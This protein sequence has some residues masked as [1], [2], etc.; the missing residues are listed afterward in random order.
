MF[1]VLNPS[2][3]KLIIRTVF[4]I[5]LLL[6]GIIS[7]RLNIDHRAEQGIYEA[8]HKVLGINVF[9]GLGYR[10]DPVNHWAQTGYTEIK[11][12]FPLWG[13]PIIVG[14]IQN[15]LVIMVIQVTAI[16]SLLF[17]IC[18][19]YIDN[20]YFLLF[21]P[22]FL[23][24]ALHATVRWADTWYVLSLLILLFSLIRY[25]EN[26][27]RI[28][29]VITFLISLVGVNIRPDFLYFLIFLFVTFFCILKISNSSLNSS[30]RCD[31]WIDS[32]ADLY[33]ECNRETFDRKHKWWLSCLHKSWTAS[34]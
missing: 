15:D 22:L 8:Y 1:N 30:C 12:T 33:M 16:V 14:L 20:F 28:Y 17:L 32:L 2:Q 19:R 25:V 31:Y 21:V 6:I 10:F 4:F 9:N 27:Y 24:I 11:A 23:P 26:E 13:Y 7:M 3:K 34:Q 29:L 5:L 18:Y